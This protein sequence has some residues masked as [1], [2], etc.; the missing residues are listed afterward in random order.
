[1]VGVKR[2]IVLLT[3]TTWSYGVVA[4]TL[5]FE[6]N[7]PSSNLGRTSFLQINHNSVL[8]NQTKHDG[9][10]AFIYLG[11]NHKYKNSF[12][13]LSKKSNLKEAATNLYRIFRLIKRKGYKK[14][15]ICKDKYYDSANI[16]VNCQFCKLEL[17]LKI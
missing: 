10:S 12:F 1:M 8:I 15:Q 11:Y 5:D 13:S 7:N 9:K 14:I 4:I 6:S 2:T 16:L 3:I 17:E